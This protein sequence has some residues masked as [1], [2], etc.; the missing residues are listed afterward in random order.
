MILKKHRVSRSVCLKAFASTGLVLGMLA[1]PVVAQNNPFAPAPAGAMDA[2]N[3]TAAPSTSAVGRAREAV[4]GADPAALNDA[5]ARMGGALR[6]RGAVGEAS[7]AVERVVIPRVKAIMGTRVFDAVTGDLLDDAQLV[8]VD[9]AEIQNLGLVDDGTQGDRIPEDGEFAKV[10]QSREFIGQAN[11]RLKERLIQ[12]IYSAEQLNPLEFYGFNIMTTERTTPAPRNRRWRLVD[13]PDGGPGKTL[14][15]V[16]T[17]KPLEVPKFR[18]WEMER[19]RKVAG[20]DGWAIRFLDEYRTD[21][22]KIDSE[23]YTIYIPQPPVVPSVP[24]PPGWSPFPNPEGAGPEAGPAGAGFSAQGFKIK[25]PPGGLPPGA[26]AGAQPYFDKGA[27]D[28]MFR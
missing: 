3:E 23:F 27:T 9:Q 7:R 13:D 20:K 24:P 8:N 6:G 11:Q 21:K 22:G 4:G 18:E 19:D 28:K 2:I 25:A 14:A 15:E 17:E 5:R 12:A 10:D 1:S 26:A 16:A